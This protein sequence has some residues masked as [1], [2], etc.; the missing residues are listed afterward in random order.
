[1]A[2]V[3]VKKLPGARKS[4]LPSFIPPQLAT[5]VKEPPSG[6][7][8]LHELKFDC[9]RDLSHRSWSRQCLEPKWKGWTEK[10][11][12]D[13]GIALLRL[14]FLLHEVLRHYRAILD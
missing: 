2:R 1:M 7:E 5:L 14:I 13:I 6:D 4:R 8:W 3:D 11:Q 12:N 9:Y 10:F